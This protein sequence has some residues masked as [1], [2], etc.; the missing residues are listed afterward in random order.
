MTRT[1]RAQIQFDF[2]VGVSIF[3]MAI[4]VAFTFVPGLIG[5]VTEGRQQGDQVAAD[6]V[7]AW[8]AEDGFRNTSRSGEVDPR[9]VRAFFDPS[10][11]GCGHEKTSAADNA[12]ITDR[13]L[14]VTVINEST[15]VCWYDDPPDSRFVKADETGVSCDHRLVTAGEPAGGGSVARATRPINMDGY[16]ATVVVRVW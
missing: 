1:E 7:A 9:C 15:Q 11:A 16:Q 10:L 14:N 4:V 8:L 5:G 12:F 13:N 6:R 2:A 3:V